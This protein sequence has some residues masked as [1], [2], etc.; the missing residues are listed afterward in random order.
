[1]FRAGAN[2][3]VRDMRQRLMFVVAVLA[4]GRRRLLIGGQGP[5]ASR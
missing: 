2:R 3:T 1:M 5:E 4:N